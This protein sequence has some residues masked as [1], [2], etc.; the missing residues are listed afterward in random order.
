MARL[1]IRDVYAT[2][3]VMSSQLYLGNIIQTNTGRVVWPGK[4]DG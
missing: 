3:E 2:A 1:L 4:G